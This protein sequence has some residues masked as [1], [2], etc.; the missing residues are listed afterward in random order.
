MKKYTAVYVANGR[1]DSP[2][3]EPVT[4]VEYIQGETLDDAIEGH[5]KHMKGYAIHDIRGEVAV[6]EGHVNQV[7]IGHGVG[8]RMVTNKD[9]I[10]TGVNNGNF[11]DLKNAEGGVQRDAL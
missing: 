6:F 8:H 1:Y 9:I 2:I 10:I 7:N 3:D 5:I 11:V 4:R